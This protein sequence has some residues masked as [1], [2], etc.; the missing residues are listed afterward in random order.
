[1]GKEY[2]LKALKK[3]LFILI[4]MMVACKVSAGF[5]AILVPIL[6]IWA[7]TRDKPVMLIFLVLL[8]TFFAISN[9]RLFANNGVTILTARVTLVIMTAMVATKLFGG[10]RATRVVT[11]FLGIMAYVFWECAVSLQGWQPII[12]YLKIILFFAIYLGLIGAA[13]QVNRSTRT[14]AKILR[15]VFLAMFCFLIFGSVLLIPSGLGMMASEDALAAIKAGEAVSLFT[16]ITCHS[17]VLGPLMG[18]LGTFL[19]ADLVFS[20][21]K[22]DKLYVTLLLCC[23]LL[24]VRSSSRTGMGTLIAGWGMVTFLAMRARGLGAQWKNRLMNVAVLIVVVGGM[25]I[26]AV[27]AVREKVA[28]YVLK[29]GKDTKRMTTE[30]ILASRQGKLDEMFRHIAQK[31]FQGHGF[32]VSEDMAYEK[33]HGFVSYLTAPVEK[34]TWIF[35][36]IEEGGVIGMIIFCGWLLYLF[37]ALIKRHAYIGASAM[38]SFLVAN[39]GEFSIFSM[40]YLGGFYWALVFAGLCM[41]VQRMKGQNIPVFFVPI[42][43]VQE[44]IGM[45]EWVRKQG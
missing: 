9:R 32:Q 23:P 13:N 38:W 7:I 1:M 20:I 2:D 40:S 41:D 28:Q 44:E 43:Q 45:D 12:S 4:A 31:P 18:I 39:L 25:G 8:S 30:D 3:Y 10:G 26:V 5:A 34:G 22:W 16:G 27:P 11:P 19:L 36:I 42:E 29:Y 6:V 37:P 21:K 17:Q 15:S 14:N 35:A 33:R 24:L